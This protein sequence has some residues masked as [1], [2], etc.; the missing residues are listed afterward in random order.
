MKGKEKNNKSTLENTQVLILSTSPYN[1]SST[2][3]YAWHDRMIT[4]IGLKQSYLR[5]PKEL[6]DIISKVL[7]VNSD[8]LWRMGVV[9]EKWKKA[10]IIPILKKQNKKEIGNYRSLS[11]MQILSKIL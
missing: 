4:S 11:L 3:F 1:Q 8:K 9:A 7:S 10:N 2:H 5:V 6:T